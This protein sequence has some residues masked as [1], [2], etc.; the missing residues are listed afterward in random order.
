LNLEGTYSTNN[1]AKNGKIRKDKTKLVDFFAGDKT[2]NISVDNTTLGTNYRCFSTICD[3]SNKLYL[4]MTAVASGYSATDGHQGLF[5]VKKA[6]TAAYLAKYR[7]MQLRWNAKT[8]VDTGYRVMNFGKSKGLTFDRVL[9]Y[10]PGSM[11]KWLNDSNSE[12]A[13]ESR[14]KLYV[15]ITRARHSV[16]F[17]C[18]DKIAGIMNWTE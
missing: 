18:D 11:L 15:G 14:A 5:L 17:V 12:L 7:P 3:L 8:K 4:A 10:L 2:L 1:S 16:A 13:S 9:I 6:D